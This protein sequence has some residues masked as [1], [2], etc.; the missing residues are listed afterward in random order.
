M[1]KRYLVIGWAPLPL[2]FRLKK[3][4]P[5]TLSRKPPFNYK[6]Q[7]KSAKNWEKSPKVVQKCSKQLKTDL[8]ISFERFLTSEAHK[9]API[10]IVFFLPV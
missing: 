8:K 6:N 7:P 5:P 3:W 4:F 1:A 2:P 10:T 9:I